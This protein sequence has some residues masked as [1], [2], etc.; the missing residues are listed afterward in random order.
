MTSLK[1]RRFIKKHIRH[2]IKD[3]DMKPKQAVAVALVEA[4]EKG[5]RV[6]RA[7]PHLSRKQI[8]IILGPQMAG[9]G[10]DTARKLRK[11]FKMELR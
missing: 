4:R 10:K 8:R 11:A 3:L 2:H 6:P 1:A 7:N 5:F 9:L